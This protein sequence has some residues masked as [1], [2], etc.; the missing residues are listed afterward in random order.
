MLKI[1]NLASI[2]GDGHFWKPSL[3]Y[4]F[5][6]TANPKMEIPVLCKKEIQKIVLE[7]LKLIYF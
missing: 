3:M 7:E 5:I 6:S 4:M 1:E 2:I